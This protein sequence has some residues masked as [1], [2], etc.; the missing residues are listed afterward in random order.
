[1][2]FNDHGQVLMQL[3]SDTH[4]W[5][6]PGGSSELGDSLLQ[7]AQRELLEETGLTASS[8][9]FVTVLS[10]RE[11]RFTYPNGDEIY[12]VGA[13]FVARGLSGVL[14]SDH[15][16]LEL[17]WLARDA[18]PPNLAGPI[19]LWVVQHLESL[20]AGDFS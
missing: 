7:T 1:M 8:Y 20:F 19:T 2:A 4:T 18:L 5:G 6:F 3:R 11:F 13:V 16:S 9:E 17:R 15:E 14:Q 10:G 12:H